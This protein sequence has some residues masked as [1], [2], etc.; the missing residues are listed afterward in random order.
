MRQAE[1]GSATGPNPTVLFVDQDGSLRRV[2]QRGLKRMGY[3]V[4]LADE[5]E[6]APKLLMKDL[7]EIQVVISGHYPSMNASITP[8][9]GKGRVG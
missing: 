2:V 1:A 9:K 7:G 3:R 4:I 8:R 6:F 5:S